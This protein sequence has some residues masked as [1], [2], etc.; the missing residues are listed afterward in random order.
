VEM[1]QCANCGK[2]LRKTSHGEWPTLTDLVLMSA[3]GK[4]RDDKMMH[5]VANYWIKVIKVKPT[6]SI[7]DECFW[8]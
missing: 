2:K 5:D 8:K 4:S 1:R 6:S 3:N 7:C